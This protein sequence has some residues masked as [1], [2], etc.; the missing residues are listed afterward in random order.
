RPNREHFYL[1]SDEMSE[2]KLN[3]ENRKDSR[4]IKFRVSEDE[5]QYLTAIADQTGMSVPQLCKSVALGMKYRAPN[6]DRE[7]A[8]Q[9]AKELRKYGGNLNQ[10]ARFINMNKGQMPSSSDLALMNQQLSQIEK[11]VIDLWEQL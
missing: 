2:Q 5:Y 8:I 11:G 10:M 7:G 4:Q 3:A 9:I 1:R 6:V